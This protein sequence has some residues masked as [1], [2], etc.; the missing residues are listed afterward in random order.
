MV[1][2]M[3]LLAAGNLL[4]TAYFQQKAEIWKI[5]F[6]HR[7]SAKACPRVE[8]FPSFIRYPDSDD[9][10]GHLVYH[11]KLNTKAN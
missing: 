8:N 4:V 6:M 7:K 5:M 2:V 10:V 3:D 9:S 1:A 11:Q